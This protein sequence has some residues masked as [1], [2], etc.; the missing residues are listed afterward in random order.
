MVQWPIEMGEGEGE[1]LDLVLV[2]VLNSWGSKKHSKKLL[3]IHMG[4]GYYKLCL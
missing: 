1:G 2:L 3:A 4:L